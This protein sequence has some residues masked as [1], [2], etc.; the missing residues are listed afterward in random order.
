MKTPEIVAPRGY[1]RGTFLEQLKADTRF[2]EGWAALPAE[3]MVR[4]LQMELCEDSLLRELR[5]HIKEVH[6]VNRGR[7]FLLRVPLIG[8][9]IR[10]QHEINRL[11]LI[12]LEMSL[13]LASRIEREAARLSRDFSA[14]DRATWHQS[15]RYM[16]Q[17]WS[18]ARMAQKAIRDEWEHGRNPYHRL[19]SKS[20]Q[21]QLNPRIETAVRGL[22]EI[23]TCLLDM[24]RLGS[25]RTLIKEHGEEVEKDFP[26]L[27]DRLQSGRWHAREGSALLRRSRRFWPPVRKL[28]D[29]QARLNRL[30][31]IALEENTH[32][33]IELSAFLSRA[34]IARARHTSDS[35]CA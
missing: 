1:E 3:E 18:H 21:N 2:P 26:V 5:W 14:T 13:E 17:Q 35:P 25:F 4:Y 11:L 10:D 28:F 34:T 32:V 8:R 16:G 30:Y 6:H 27:E 29:W 22:S 20:G 7:H 12:S 19:R 9:Q 24:T 15:F 33:L 23:T 31:R